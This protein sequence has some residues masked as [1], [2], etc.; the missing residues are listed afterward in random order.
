MLGRGSNARSSWGAAR[1]P[2]HGPGSC[3]RR[4][5]NK[6]RADCCR[7]WKRLEGSV[8]GESGLRFRAR[9]QVL[10][11]G[12]GPGALIT[13]DHSVV[14]GVRGLPER[15]RCSPEHNR[16]ARPEPP[17]Q[18][19]KLAPESHRS[20][21][22]IARDAEASQRP[23]GHVPRTHTDDAQ[24]RCPAAVTDT[25]DNDM[26]CDSAARD[27]VHFL[28]ARP[29]DLRQPRGTWGSRERRCSRRVWGAQPPVTGSLRRDPER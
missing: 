28:A 2:L 23:L 29:D 25:D 5:A 14:C 22:R 6:S 17:D 12:F 4:R 26:R 16:P 9:C 13:G 7:V 20:A 1:S 8:S 21:M 3:V 10:F 27:A 24:L 15:P 11:G 18:P 19:E